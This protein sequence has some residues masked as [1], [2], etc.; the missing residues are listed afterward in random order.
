VRHTGVV[1]KS[2]P[3]G[4]YVH[5]PFCAHRCD[6]C[7][8]ATWTDR[9][10]LIDRYIDACLIDLRRQL[11]ERP[12][13]RAT[14]VFFG[15]GTPSL[16]PPERLMTVLDAIPLA[17]GAEV[18]VECNPES[19]T[20]EVA[21]VYAAHRVNRVS[22][23][24]Q[25]FVPHVLTSLGRVHDPDNVTRA[26]RAARTA[27]IQRLNLDIIYGAA[28]ESVADW[29]TT[30]DATIALGPDHVSAYAL[31]VEAG[32]PLARK[33]A[34]GERGATD[35]DDQATKYELADEVLSAAGYD[36]YEISNW[37]QPGE[38]CHHNLVYWR[39]GDYLAIGCA[40]HGFTDGRRWWNVR[41]IDRYIERIERGEAAE[42]GEERLDPQ[43]AADE[44]FGLALRLSEGVTVPSGAESVA[45][46]LVDVGL[47]EPA[48][49]ARRVRLTRRGRLL[50]NDVTTRLQ[51]AVGP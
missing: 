23:G 36:W 21:A 30:L 8:F 2:D 3:L 33:I 29:R 4:V 26:V 20:A 27:G 49:E 44:A 42:A 34:R 41:S 13:A 25:S 32:T 47:L 45:A 22:I 5:I 51:L 37:A 14:S 50:A 35:D 18:T 19:F 17:D 31:T 40:A 16:I 39:G 6:Y 43:A 11:G 1:S 38:A 9:D 12:V 46:E 48:S 24:A 7:D 15:G 10:H 28:G